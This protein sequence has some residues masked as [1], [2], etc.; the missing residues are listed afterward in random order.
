MKKQKLSL[1]SGIFAGMVQEVNQ[2]LADAFDGMKAKQ[3]EESTVTV[4]ISL[5]LT[6]KPVVQD[7]GRVRAVQVPVISYKLQNSM[8][9][10]VSSAGVMDTGGMELEQNP[11]GSYVL[12]PSVGSQVT[13]DELPDEQE[14]DEDAAYL[15]ALAEEYPI[16]QEPDEPEEEPKKDEPHVYAGL[17]YSEPLM[18]EY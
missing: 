3:I 8:K 10:V 6:E 11:D 4:K 9:Y 15:D 1:Y 17:A 7:D 5:A 12:S 14:P 18:G 2:T 16:E 13:M